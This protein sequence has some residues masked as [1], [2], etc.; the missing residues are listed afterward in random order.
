MTIRQKLSD[1][2]QNFD[3]LGSLCPVTMLLNS[4]MQKAWQTYVDWVQKLPTQIDVSHRTWRKELHNLKKIKLPRFALS[5][6]QLERFESHFTCDTTE[7]T[8]AVCENEV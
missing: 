2:A 3:P 5:K 4:M 7:E 1:I 8:Y 6:E